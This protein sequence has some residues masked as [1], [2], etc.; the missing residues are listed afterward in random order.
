[1]YMRTTIAFDVYGT[2]VSPLAIADH[3]KSLA[4]ERAASFAELWRT[5]QLEYSFRR[6]L[7]R[8]YRPF[9]VCTWEALLYTEK[10]LGI[11]LAEGARTT[12]IEH[13]K[14]LPPFPDAA[15]G[16]ASIKTDGHFLAAFSN[17][18][19][20]VI[21]TVLEKAGLLSFLD[22]VVSADEV[23]TFKP[24]PAIYAHAVKRLGQNANATWLVSSNP[25]DII[26]AKSAGLRTAWVKRD[27]NA[28]FDPWGVEPDLVVSGLDQ[29]APLFGNDQPS[30]T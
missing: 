19:A 25:F 11:V 2:L 23:R 17:G 10:A 21:R 27:P 14:D 5:K 4:G 6:G 30:R 12:L 16:L 22:D 28:V 3:L 29:L 26:G 13:Y 9:S 24:D 7:M 20:E 18:E 15:P 1:M 8:S